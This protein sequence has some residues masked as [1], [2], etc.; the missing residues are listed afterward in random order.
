RLSFSLLLPDRRFLG[1]VR[2]RD[3]P[4]KDVR[5]MLESAGGRAAHRIARAR[6]PDGRVIAAGHGKDDLRPSPRPSSG[7][8]EASVSPPL[9]RVAAFAGVLFDLEAQREQGEH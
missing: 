9:W 5:L 7:P 4:G 3:G 8:H 2:A 6:D 1:G